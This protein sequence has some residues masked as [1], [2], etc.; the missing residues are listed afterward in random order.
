MS[1]AKR[2]PSPAA[3]FICTKTGR[4]PR[5]RQGAFG[6]TYPLPPV[7]MKFTAPAVAVDDAIVLTNNM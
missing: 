3:A 4:L 6:A 5:E 7:S 1:D 2:P